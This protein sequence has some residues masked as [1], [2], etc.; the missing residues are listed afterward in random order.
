MTYND[1]DDEADIKR[2]QDLALAVAIEIGGTWEPGRY[3]EA[4]KERRFNWEHTEQVIKLASGRTLILKMDEPRRG[5]V[6]VHGV[7]PRY[8]N[9]QTIHAADNI[10][11]VI[12]CSMERTPEAIARDIENRIF[13][14]FSA[15][16]TL[17]EEHKA[18]D[19]DNVQW[20]REIAAKMIQSDFMPSSHAQW[21]KPEEIKEDSAQ[22]YTHLKGCSRIEIKGTRRVIS[23]QMNQSISAEPDEAIE[24]MRKIDALVS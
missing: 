4:G 1:R 17:A 23:F 12:T 20:V 6:T 16:Y 5:R 7:L 15:A 10:N 9:G 21:K 14:D 19:L 13:P 11:P 3:R 22:V 18:R 24:L 8:L 2:Y